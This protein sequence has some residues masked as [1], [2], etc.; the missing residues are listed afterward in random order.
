[1][2]NPATPQAAAPQPAT[3]EAKQPTA[4]EV[5]AADKARR[6]GVRAE[7]AVA[8]KMAGADASALAKLQQECEDDSGCTP[9]AAAR[10]ILAAMAQRHVDPVG[11]TH[12]ETVEDE[13]DK[14]RDSIV[15]S[16]LARA[17][18]ADAAD[19]SV[20]GITAAPTLEG[21]LIYQDTGDASTSRLIAL[22]DQATGLPVAGGA[23]QADIAWSN[24][25]TKIFKL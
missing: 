23:T 1:M 9:E 19:C 2:P 12:I 10:K 17:G 11:A 5:L 20:T 4:A 14:R 24:G 15:A 25:A 7:F 13:E 21:I 6:A 18:V 3:P 22:I 8:A 16:L